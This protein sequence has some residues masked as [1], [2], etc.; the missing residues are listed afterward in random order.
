MCRCVR[1]GRRRDGIDVG[2]SFLAPELGH[3]GIPLRDWTRNSTTARTVFRSDKNEPATPAMQEQR[4][5]RARPS[6]ETSGSRVRSVASIS[7]ERTLLV[8][9]TTWTLTARTTCLFRRRSVFG[10]VYKDVC[11]KCFGLLPVEEQ[12]W[13]QR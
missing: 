6:L 2:R 5:T 12:L 13:L 8:T 9:A 10:I 4:W 11:H 7:F 3:F 1:V